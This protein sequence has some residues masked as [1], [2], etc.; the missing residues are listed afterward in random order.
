MAD[1][2]NENKPFRSSMLEPDSD[3]KL[4]KTFIWIG[5]GVVAIGLLY[6]TLYSNFFKKT[7]KPVSEEVV[8]NFAP[9]TPDTLS[10]AP[11]DSSAALDDSLYQSNPDENTGAIPET[12]ETAPEMQKPVSEPEKKPESKPV[13]KKQEITAK[14][15]PKGSFTIYVASFDQKAKA[16]NEVKRLTKKHIDSFIVHKDGRY[17]IAVGKYTTREEAKKDLN[18]YK[19]SIN[20]GAWVDKI[21]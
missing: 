3:P 16:E 21:N 2:K 20:D 17:R 13:E 5:I 9:L 11:Y 7:E 18:Q 8:T 6:F 10:E 1:S 15:T 14:Q 19:K 12:H 4:K